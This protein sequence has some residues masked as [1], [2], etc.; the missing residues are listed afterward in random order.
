MRVAAG[1]LGLFALLLGCG[2]ARAQ[3][4][5][6]L[7][8]AA[9][10]QRVSAIDVPPGSLPAVLETLGKQTGLRFLL[11]DSAIAAMPFGEA[12][13]IE[14]QI[15]ERTVRDALGEILDRIGLVMQV[16][17]DRVELSAAPAAER[18]G[19]ALELDE[20]ALLQQ[21]AAQR[22]DALMSSGAL[23]LAASAGVQAAGAEALA[24]FEAALRGASQGN[25]LR[26]LER[27]AQRFGWLWSPS[28]SLV[29]LMLPLEDV[30]RRL[31]RRIS[32]NYL[33]RPLDDVLVDVGARA[34]VTMLFEPGVLQRVDATRRLLDLVHRD[35]TLRQTL[36]R[37][38]G[39]TGLRYEATAEGVRISGPATS[40][41]AGDP[42]AARGPASAPASPLRAFVR[43]EVQLRAGEVVDMLVP[44]DQLPPDARR[45]C[46]E[47]FREFLVTLRQ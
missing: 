23:K 43:L 6:E 45:A 10:D 16:V 5:R 4:P 37:L 46:E 36:E 9:L 12:T 38:C 3:T 20:V 35:T 33:R 39:S 18:L 7:V 32:L 8:E 17:E 25:A 26:Q 44:L 2:S 13:Q 29:E 1:Y 41:Q 28:G 31:D 22:A 42:S 15:R 24:R 34:G 19:R 14:L 21:L 40:A 27:V 30:Q 11:R 47:R